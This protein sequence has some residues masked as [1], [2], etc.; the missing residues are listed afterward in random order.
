MILEWSDDDLA[1]QA[2]A[3]IVAGFGTP[4][5]LLCFVSYELARHP[6][7][8]Q[9]LQMEIDEV[10]KATNSKPTYADL[11]NMK[12]IDMVISGKF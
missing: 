10:A 5:S 7:V 12:Y 2:M 11:Q 4:S 6:E 3:F 8:Q 1:A 9:K